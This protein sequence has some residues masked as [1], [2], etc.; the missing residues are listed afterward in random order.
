MLL[1]IFNLLFSE[2]WVKSNCS[3]GDQVQVRHFMPVKNLWKYFQ[4]YS[5]ETITWNIIRQTN[6]YLLYKYYAGT[7]LEY[8]LFLHYK[9]TFL[10]FITNLIFNLQN[11]KKLAPK[12]K[13]WPLPENLWLL[14][15]NLPIP[16]RLFHLTP[17]HLKTQ[18]LCKNR[19]TT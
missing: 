6:I 10:G 16:L 19:N 9:N 3:I 12:M 15:G 14:K 17:F 18:F 11:L 1:K 2:C 8:F 5:R 13:P 7:I 4:S